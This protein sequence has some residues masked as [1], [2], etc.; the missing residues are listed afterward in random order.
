MICRGCNVD[1]EAV[2]EVAEEEERERL[3]ATVL[4]VDDALRSTWV[5]SDPAPSA[6]R[7][8]PSRLRRNSSELRAFC[9]ATEGSASL[10]L[11]PLALF[12]RTPPPPQAPAPPRRGLLGAV[13]G[14]LLFEFDGA[15]GW[16]MRREMPDW[17]D[18]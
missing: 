11:A 12:L 4:L 3:M 10:L 15:A 9:R 6:P 14:R 8:L 18:C 7:F 13:R 16:K 5:F 2:D 17:E 1:P